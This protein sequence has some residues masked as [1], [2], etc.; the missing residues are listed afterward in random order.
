MVKGEVS[1][2]EA[3]VGY[4]ARSQY[5]VATMTARRLP[6][7]KVHVCGQSSYAPVLWLL[8]HLSGDTDIE[9]AARDSGLLTR[10]ATVDGAGWEHA[11]LQ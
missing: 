6:G 4:V 8:M 2:R 7:P 11:A 5:H 1:I 3:K 10:R 9:A